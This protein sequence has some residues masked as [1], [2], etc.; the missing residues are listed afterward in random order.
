M[1]IVTPHSGRVFA[2]RVG[3]KE[4]TGG[5]PSAP[6]CKTKIGGVHMAKVLKTGNM[7][8]CIGCFSCVLVCAAVNRKS[9]SL[10]KSCIKIKTYGGIAGKFVET[11]CHAC[12]DPACAEVCPANA[13]LLRK[14]GGVLVD[15]DKCIGCRRSVSA[16]IVSAVDFDEDLKQPIICHHC[17][18]CARYC[19]HDCLSLED[20]T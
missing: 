5:L 8:K 19:P 7:S 6:T 17:G 16:C 15:A 4:T 10:Q 3:H 18:V 9:H 12:R 20:V 1:A 14:G 2:S 11:V 13:L